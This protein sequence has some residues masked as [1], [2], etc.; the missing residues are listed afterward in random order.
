MSRRRSGQRGAALVEFAFVAFQLVV[1]LLS[2]VEFGRM[3]LV[4]TAV[5]NSARTAVRYAIVHGATRTGSGI[6]GPSG[7]GS[8]AQIENNIRY[9]A[10]AGLMTTS[11]LVLAVSYP[12]GNNGTGS[13]VRVTV[14]YPYDP[15][16]FL[17]LG[18]NLSTTAEGI[19][20]F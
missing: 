3:V 1:V 14:T 16:T 15:F 10:G 18:V 2:V 7:P 6:D 19:I 11:R 20:C 12:D 9:Y 8:V 4:S 5:A 17:P 13:R